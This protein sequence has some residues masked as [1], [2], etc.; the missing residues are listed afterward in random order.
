MTI[1]PK[2]F[3]PEWTFGPETFGLMDIWARM[4]FGVLTFGP[5][6][7]RAKMKHTSDEQPSFILAKMSMGPNVSGPNVH[8]GPNVPGPNEIQP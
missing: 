5:I 2:K 6:D 4:T 8:S 7:I 1:G 3:G